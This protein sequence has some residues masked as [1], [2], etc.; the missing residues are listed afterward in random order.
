MK[1]HIFVY[2]LFLRQKNKK[3]LYIYFLKNIKKRKNDLL[4]ISA[5]GTKYIKLFTI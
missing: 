2:K 4:S 1:I 3:L 5:L